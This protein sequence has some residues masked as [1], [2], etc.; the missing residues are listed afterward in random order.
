MKF[1]KF[2]SFLDV[3]Q[4]HYLLNTINSALIELDDEHYE[5]LKK[6]FYLN[7]PDVIETD[8]KNVLADNGFLIEDTIDEY[9]SIRNKYLFSKYNVSYNLKLDIAVTNKCNFSC[10]YC[11]EN[12]SDSKMSFELNDEIKSKFCNNLRKY[13]NHMIMNYK[14]KSLQVTWY[15]GEPSLE[16]SLIFTL[17]NEFIKLGNEH[18]IRY[19]NV[20][21]TNGFLID[22]SIATK[23]S[24]QNT[25]YVQITV[26]GP[27]IIHD[28]RRYLANKKG[29]YS[30]ILDGI[31]NLLKNGVNTVVRVNIDKGNID[32]I[33]ILIEELYS[34]FQTFVG[35]GLLSLDLARVF[36]HRDSFSLSEFYSK[37]KIIMK[38]AVKL[39]FINPSLESGGVR[40]YCNA[41]TDVLS[42][43][44]I[45]VFGNIYKCWNYVFVKDS[46]YCTLDE[47][48][49]NNFEILPQNKNRLDYVEK[50]SLLNTNNGQCL[51]CKYITYC[52]GLCPDVR[53]KIANGEEEN[54]YKNE[55]CKSIVEDLI[56]EQIKLIYNTD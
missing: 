37:R 4:H 55:K 9:L 44:T 8:E 35:K 24:Q 36:G 6:A 54:I 1:T 7:N 15:G 51:K 14:V 19:K 32:Y 45:D 33:E 10:V 23:L 13:L 46:S 38:K 11:Y 41:E 2:Y 30:K 40:A 49:E 27:E 12:F 50:V 53:K 56:K 20:I 52:A 31:Y 3:N 17:N 43:L 39:G 26:D 29:T 47:L 28:K 21:V 42:N 5:K 25:E 18:H 22:E 16:W 34:R 48:I